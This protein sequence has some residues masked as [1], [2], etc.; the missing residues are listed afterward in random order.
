MDNR[1]DNYRDRGER[2]QSA[3][4]SRGRSGGR[5]EFQVNLDANLKG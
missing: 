4:Y 1:A 3:S 2:G 5:G